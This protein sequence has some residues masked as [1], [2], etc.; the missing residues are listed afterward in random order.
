MPS[1]LPGSPSKTPPA[2]PGSGEE[3]LLLGSGTTPDTI[4]EFAAVVD[5]AIAGSWL[6]VDGKVSNPV[7]PARAVEFVAAARNVGWV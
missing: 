6:K 3:P 5:G 7:D 4:A 1:R 2:T